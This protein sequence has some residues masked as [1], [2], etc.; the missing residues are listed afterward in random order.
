M[1]NYFNVTG[2]TPVPPSS[3]YHPTAPQ[4]PQ[5]DKAAV[6]NFLAIVFII[7]GG[8]SLIASLAIANMH[9]DFDWLIFGS[10]VVVSLFNFGWA[11]VM[12]VCALYIRVHDKSQPL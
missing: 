2:Q 9:Y 8:I 3:P 6:V 1:N 12:Y 5:N 7:M 4:Q 10:G 11:V